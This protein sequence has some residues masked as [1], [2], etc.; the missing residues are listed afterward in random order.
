MKLYILQKSNKCATHRML[1]KIM[2]SRRYYFYHRPF[3]DPLESDMPDQRPIR[4][5]SETYRIPTCLTGDP[6]EILICVIRVP[7]ETN[8]PDR[9]PTCPIGDQHAP[10]QTDMPHQRRTFTIGDRHA[11]GNPSEF[12]HI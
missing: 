1:V 6:S 11:C 3:G 10:S 4:D 9:R 8:M 5:L 12:K 2:N 7:S